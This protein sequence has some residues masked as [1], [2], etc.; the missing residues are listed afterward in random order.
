M[1]SGEKVWVRK[2]N[3]PKFFPKWDLEKSIAGEEV[4]EITNIL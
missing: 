1:G 4:I 2:E 3:D